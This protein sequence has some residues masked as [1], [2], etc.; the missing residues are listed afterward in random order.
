[1]KFIRNFI[2]IIQKS[3]TLLR[4]SESYNLRLILL[5]N[6]CFLNSS[7]LIFLSNLRHINC[8]VVSILLDLYLIIQF[9]DRFIYLIYIIL[10]YKTSA[11][12]L[13]DF[14]NFNTLYKLSK[15]RKQYSIKNII[16]SKNIKKEKIKNK[17]KIKKEIKKKK[18]S[19]NIL[20]LFKIEKV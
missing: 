11:L 6:H 19:I 12:L 5:I 1:M 20:F 9:K 8:A 7:R 14:E 13:S 10:S 4:L 15:L 3:L 17:L 18:K 2:L 16:I